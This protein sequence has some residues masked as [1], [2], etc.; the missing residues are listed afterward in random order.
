MNRKS[1]LLF[2]LFLAGCIPP[3][4]FSDLLVGS[5][6]TNSIRRYDDNGNYLG[7]F[8]PPGNGGLDLPDGMAFGPDGNLYVSSSDSNQILRY[9][10]QSGR[11]IDVFAEAGLSAPGNLQFGPDQMLYVCN[12]NTG[13][14]FRFDPKDNSSLT[15]FA[16][17]GGLN[18]PVGLLWKDGLLYVA[19]FAGGA[20]RRYD[21]QTGAFVDLFAT[22]PTP[23]MTSP[24]PLL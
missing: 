6:Q 14:V 4:A 8:V 13:E 22:V 5:W 7:D 20:I 23:L 17:G 3:A 12:K 11:F 19:D 1:W 16:S 2:I 21:A 9:N 10:G 18:N 24:L 15:V